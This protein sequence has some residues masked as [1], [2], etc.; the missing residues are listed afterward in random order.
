MDLAAIR[1]FVLT[2]TDLD[3]EDLPD[4]LLDAFC[5]EASRKIERAE[6]RW[7]MYESQWTLNTETGVAAYDLTSLASATSDV[8]RDVSGVS[9]DGKPLRWV[10]PDEARAAA[11]TSGTSGPRAWSQWGNAVTLY[12]T[13]SSD[14]VLDVYGYRAPRD[15]VAAGSGA[16][17]DMDPD[18][19]LTLATWVLSRA[20]AQQED[21]ELASYF[22]QT[23]DQELEAFRRRYVDSPPAQ[24]FVLGQGRN[25]SMPFDR[26]RY[27][28]EA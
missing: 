6:K 13:P 12:P 15:W 28:W 22:A 26:L 9:A 19:H 25:E 14:A 2:H 5:R 1:D 23:F 20:Y 3:S 8:C 7:P 21:T 4:R 27:P 18:L 11:I 10:G 24:P 17:P 16:E